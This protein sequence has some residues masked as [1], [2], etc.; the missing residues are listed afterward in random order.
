MTRVRRL[1]V[2]TIAAVLTMA[3]VGWGFMIVFNMLNTLVQISAA[4]EL[5]GRVMSIYS[6]IFFGTTNAMDGLM[7]RQALS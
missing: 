4:D 7:E 5:R 6:L 3:G 1:G 2:A